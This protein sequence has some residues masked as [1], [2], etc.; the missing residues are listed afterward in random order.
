MC[1][2]D[3]ADGR[4]I[5][6]HETIRKARKEHRCTE[7]RR[8]IQIGESYLHEGTLWEGKKD[9]VKTCSHCQ[10]VRQWLSA[11]CGGWIYGGV[12]EDIQEHAGEG[13][14]GK[15][16]IMLAAGMSRQWRKRSGEM[17]RVPSVPKTTHDTHRPGG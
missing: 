6:L 8:V 5:V 2:I 13:W 14:Y 16:V 11:E 1:M 12:S 17:W 7:C 4:C 10:V 15:G 9:T 3:D